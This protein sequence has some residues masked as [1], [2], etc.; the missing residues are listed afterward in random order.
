MSV[1]ERVPAPAGTRGEVVAGF[2][3]VRELLDHFSE[4]DPGYGA[5]LCAYHGSR[6]VVDLVCGTAQQRDTV[7]PVFSAT[8][9]AAA[10]VIGCLVDDGLLDLDAPVCRYWPEFA[11]HGRDRLQLRDLLSHQGG[12]VNTP[13]GLTPAEIITDPRAGAEKLADSRPLWRP[14]SMF[15]YHGITLGVLMQ[16]LVR[17]VTGTSLQ[18]LFE[19]RVRRPREIDF[20][21]GFPQSQERRFRAVANPPGQPAAPIPAPC[22]SFLAAMLSIVG[23]PS[24]L[25]TGPYSPNHRE[26]REHGPAGFGGIGSARGLAR[27]YAAALG[28]VG[29]PLFSADTRAAMT[30][31]LVHGV[32]RVLDETRSYAVVFQIPGPPNLPFGS[33]RAF[34]HDGAGGALS[35]ADPSYDLAFGYLPAYMAPPGDLRSME[36]SRTL[37]ACLS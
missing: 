35:F 29:A 15:G 4:T 6:V 33:F 3:P 22:D 16:E 26:V 14:G 13:E 7:M 23:E 36:L 30:E 24:D 37:R 21:I 5:Q 9:G 32:D 1:A 27:L 8:K 34:G 20:H 12:L 31:P 18:E 19:Q 10:M 11:A 2:E 28:N 17:R 25:I